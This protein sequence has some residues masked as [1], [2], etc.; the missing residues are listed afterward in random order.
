MVVE[1]WIGGGMGWNWALFGGSVVSMVVSMGGVGSEMVAMCMD[2]GG[3]MGEALAGVGK[4]DCVGRE[5]WG[6][7]ASAVKGLILMLGWV[8]CICIR[9]A[10]ISAR[11]WLNL[12]S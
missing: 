6:V 11:I 3:G 5:M 8:C 4:V 9:K 2:G 1:I 12:E 7:L 10:R